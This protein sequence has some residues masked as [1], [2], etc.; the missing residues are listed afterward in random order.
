MS[1]VNSKA[2]LTEEIVKEALRYGN[3][4]GAVCVQRMGGIPALP[5][6]EEI[7]T[8]LNK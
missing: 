6:K 1:G 2:D 5:T 3:A 4:S 8:Y 7:E